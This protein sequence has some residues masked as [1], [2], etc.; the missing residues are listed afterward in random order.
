[1]RGDLPLDTPVAV[2]GFAVETS[3][4]LIFTVKG[5]VHPPDAIVAYLRYVPDSAG[6]RECGSRRYRRV[7]RF[8]EQEGL[9]S[10]H[11]PVYLREDSVFGITL[12]AVPKGD[13]R[14]IFD[15]CQRL[16]D[17][18]ERG[19]AGRLEEAVLGLTELVREA[20]GVP[21][22]ALGLSGSALLNLHHVGSDIDLVV[23]GDEESR[24]VYRAL[25]GL[26]RERS[27]LV[28]RPRAE[29]LAAIHDEHR[30]DTPISRTDFARLQARKVNEGRF[31]GRPYFFR[32]VK[33]RAQVKERYGDLRYK[34]QGPVLIRARVEGHEE[35]IFTP[36]RYQVEHVTFLQ[37]V[38]TEDLREIVSF[39]GRF[40]DQARSGEWVVARGELERVVPLQR[41]SYA[42]L[43]VGGQPGD[44]L[45]S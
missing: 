25:T 38:P 36:C 29:E 2:E 42:R 39:R 5:I 32:F 24:A 27:A 16:K 19:P 8:Q 28:R 26:L 41:P 18:L 21:P 12:Q 10:A 22:E 14:R 35:A 40:A 33:K 1:M 4:G 6:D 30:L 43:I 37:G 11:W 31:Q 20:A 17:L 23:Y 45:V 34:P 44:Y 9:L 7:Y 15:P 13:I 3:E